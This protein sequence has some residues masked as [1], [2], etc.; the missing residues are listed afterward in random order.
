MSELI[1]AD[2]LNL[3]NNYRKANNIFSMFLNRLKM[4]LFE[5]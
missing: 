1:P 2:S 5:I 4:L 3:G